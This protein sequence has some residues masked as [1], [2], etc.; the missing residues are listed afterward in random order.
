MLHCPAARAG[1]V[2]TAVWNSLEGQDSGDVDDASFAAPSLRS[3]NHE[4]SPFLLDQLCVISLHASLLD[5][6]G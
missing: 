5:G 3:H 2:P 4:L 1:V 6:Q